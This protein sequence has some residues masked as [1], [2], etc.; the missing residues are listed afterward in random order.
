MISCKI[1]LSWFANSVSFSFSIAVF[2]FS[3]P[4]IG[5]EGKISSRIDEILPFGVFFE[6]ASGRPSQHVLRI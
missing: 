4:A 2:M 5:L 3:C 6:K 1:I